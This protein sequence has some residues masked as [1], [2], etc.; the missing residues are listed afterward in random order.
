MESSLPDNSGAG[1]SIEVFVDCAVDAFEL[2]GPL[3]QLGACPKGES[4]SRARLRNGLPED[5]RI[6]FEWAEETEIER[7][8]LPD[9]VAPAVLWIDALRC[10]LQPR[11]A[12]EEMLRILSPGGVLLVC[13]SSAVSVPDQAS[14]DW[15]LTP[16]GLE[17]L[18]SGMEARLIG[19]QGSEH[20]PHTLYGVGFKPPLDG[21]VLQ[22]TNRFLARF[23]AR[24]A[25]LAE[26]VGWPVRLKQ[27]LAS[28]AG[29]RTQRRQRRDDYQVQLA[30]HFSVGRRHRHEAL[31]SC[32]SADETGTRLDRM[33]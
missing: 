22:G 4:E 8:P 32:L 21:A 1:D 25:Q 20:S 23:P 10:A 7:L 11:L 6:D 33:E 29:S 5:L 18:L 15:R 17:Q 9:G 16:R 12:V 28:L 30:V 24:I 3:Y 2:A 13:A 26:S 19:W 31:G 27:F 14:T